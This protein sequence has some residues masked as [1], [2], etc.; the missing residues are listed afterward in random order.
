MS[1][2]AFNFISSQGYVDY[3][4]AVNFM[5]KRVAEI[6]NALEVETVWF[7]E[8]NS[9]YTAG[10]SANDADL[11][12]KNR[13]PIYQTGR[14]GQYTYHGPCQLIAYIMVNINERK[15]G[16]RE[17]I[18]CLEKVIIETLAFFGII[19]EVHDG[20]VGVWVNDSHNGETKIA[21]IGVRV[22]RGVTYH[23]IAIN[24]NPDLSAFTGIVPCG[25]R[26]YGVTSLH[27]LNVK[28]TRSEVEAIF[29]QK[30]KENILHISEKA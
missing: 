10:T 13:F 7:L 18:Q 11:I 12:D 3:N 30:F 2:Y 14:G 17:Y 8:H 6:K 15:I 1:V 21:A 16:I 29:Q 20:R 26:E 9:L 25:I 24:I 22:R 4:M 23:G 28:C 27:K 5:E 19:G